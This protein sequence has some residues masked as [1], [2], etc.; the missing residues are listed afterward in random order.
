MWRA[1]QVGPTIVNRKL[2]I[3][4]LNAALAATCHL[5]QQ[6]C[7]DLTEAIGLKRSSSLVDKPMRQI[8]DKHKCVG[9]TNEFF[10]TLDTHY[11]HE[12]GVRERE[13]QCV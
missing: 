9:H 2:V 11:S 4:A 6:L 12:S 10:D 7:V 5:R 3:F 8:I 1:P 13:R